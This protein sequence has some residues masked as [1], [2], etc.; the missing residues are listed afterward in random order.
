M[1]TDN[2]CT[3]C[4]CD[5]MHRYFQRSRPARGVVDHENLPTVVFLTACT[6]DRRKWLTDAKVHRLLREVWREA[7]RWH[8]GRYVLMP[9]H[10][11]LFACPGEQ[12]CQF[13]AWVKFWKS[14]ISRRVQDP[15][16]RWQKSFVPPQNSDL[17]GSGRPVCLRANESRSG[18]F[19][20][21]SRGMG[22][23]RRNL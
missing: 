6:K 13:D 4:Y 14:Q 17:R 11:H 2:I 5:K 9:D 7:Q 1:N 12:A 19:G 8:V 16:C 20:E 22:I 23:S 15:S 10:V 21:I 18:R 3:L